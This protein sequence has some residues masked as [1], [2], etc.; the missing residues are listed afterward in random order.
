MIVFRVVL[1]ICQSS[2]ICF[3]ECCFL[4]AFCGQEVAVVAKAAQAAVL[5]HRMAFCQ[6]HLG[7][8][9]PLGGDVLVN[10]GSCRIFEDPEQVG[11]A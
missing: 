11:A 6:Q 10:G 4:S 9:D 5:C 8:R 3:W 7:P 2:H 1:G